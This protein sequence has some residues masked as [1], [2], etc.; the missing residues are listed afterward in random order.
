MCF[1][2]S[3]RNSEIN[4]ESSTRSRLGIN[5]TSPAS[6][7]FVM[8][9]DNL[10]AYQVF[11]T[12]QLP[13]FTGSHACQIRV[14]QLVQLLYTLLTS[15]IRKEK[16]NILIIPANRKRSTPSSRTVNASSIRFSNK[17]RN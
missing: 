5:A 4:R 13:F 2:L 11:R 14:K 6:R 16:T 10:L 12:A 15:R 9:T 3:A 1:F 8:V 7:K 17:K